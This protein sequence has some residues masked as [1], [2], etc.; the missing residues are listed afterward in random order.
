MISPLLPLPAAMLSSGKKPNPFFSDGTFPGAVCHSPPRIFPRPAA[1]RHFLPYVNNRRLPPLYLLTTWKHSL[2]P[3]SPCRAD[4]GSDSG[5]IRF[6]SGRKYSGLPCR[7]GFLLPAKCRDHSPVTAP[8]PP[9]MPCCAPFFPHPRVADLRPDT[10]E[11]SPDGRY[12]TAASNG[13]SWA[14][15][16]HA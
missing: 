14:S 13:P 9:Q 8:S 7:A 2:L 4:P 1:G 3:P 11:T 6:F 12:N 15:G 5:R 10:C 16:H